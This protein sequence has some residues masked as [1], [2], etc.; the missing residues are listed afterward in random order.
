MEGKP[1]LLDMVKRTEVRAVTDPIEHKGFAGETWRLLR[2]QCSWLPMLPPLMPA[3]NSPGGGRAMPAGTWTQMRALGT[4]GASLRMRAWSYCRYGWQR[5]LPAGT[6]TQ[7][8]ALSA[9]L[10]AWSHCGCGPGATVPT[11][12]T[13]N[14]HTLLQRCQAPVTPGACG[15]MM[16][17]G[18]RYAALE[19]YTLSQCKRKVAVVI[20][21]DRLAGR[22]D[23]ARFYRQAVVAAALDFSEQI[24]VCLRSALRGGIHVLDCQARHG[25][26]N[27]SKALQQ[28]WADK[29]RPN[30]YVPVKTFV[31]AFQERPRGQAIN[32]K[33]ELRTPY[34][35]T[36]APEDALVRTKYALP[37]SKVFRSSCRST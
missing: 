19:Q 21:I 4:L 35:P 30:R 13:G 11:A 37:P 20:G 16:R 32:C 18:A 23:L 28:Y 33:A 36:Q 10:W 9:S 29:L 3:P 8:R 15:C 2:T 14:T 27:I 6:L 5:A 1:L 26:Y 24:N 25:V 34:D 7:M 22:T 17:Y 31:R 12:G